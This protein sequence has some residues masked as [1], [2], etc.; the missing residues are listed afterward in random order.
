MFFDFLID[1]TSK[2]IHDFLLIV[3]LSTI[4]A[5]IPFDLND[6]LNTLDFIFSNL[7]ECMVSIRFQ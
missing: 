4:S 5:F 7:I 3:M 1:I 2:R 6:N